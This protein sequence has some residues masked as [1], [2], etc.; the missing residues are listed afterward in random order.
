MNGRTIFRWA[1]PVLAGLA[2]AS[3]GV[4]VARSNMQGSEEPTASAL[5]QPITDLSPATPV[6]GALG[7][8][9]PSGGIRRS[10]PNARAWWRRWMPASV[11]G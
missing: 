3:A 2:L 8:V 11:T 1:L 5:A 4:S 6:V 10:R 9:E 7:R